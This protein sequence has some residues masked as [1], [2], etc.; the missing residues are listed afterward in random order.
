MALV[1]IDSVIR[2]LLQK[3]G[4]LDPPQGIELLSYKR[5]RSIAVLLRDDNTFLVR[6]RGYRE[7]EQIVARA[8]L[9][10]QLKALIK[11]EFPRSRKIRMYQIDDPC[12]LE[13]IR[14][15]L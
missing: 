6:E 2:S 13:K 8:D 12:D 10:K 1:N 15:K 9:Q 14:K 4:K 11:Y 5:N 3:L 7:E